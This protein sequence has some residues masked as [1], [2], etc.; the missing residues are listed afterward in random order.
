MTISRLLSVAC[1]CTLVCVTTSTHSALLSRLGGQAYYD[2][3]LEITWLTDANLAASETF[4]TAGILANGAM[5][6]NTAQN[7][8]T[9]MNADGGAGYLDFNE[10]RLPTTAPI[11]EVA[12][13]ITF[14]NNGSTDRGYHISAPGTEFDGNIGSEMAYMFYTNLG[15]LGFCTPNG[16]GSST[17][18]IEQSGW[19][20]ND[21]G[22]FDTLLPTTYLS[23]S[24]SPFEPVPD[25]VWVFSTSTGLQGAQ[26]KTSL[27]FAWAVANG[28]AFIPIPP[29][30]WLFGSGLLGLIAIARRKKAS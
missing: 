1:A 4:S 16:S 2:D 13:D 27:G 20:L 10:W 24:I 19:G 14:S 7:W 6:W 29:S 12:F 15:N 9:A 30:V 26:L 21:L 11:D 28:D 8:I 18:C 5:A 17:S 23:D 25:Y 22:N 3:V